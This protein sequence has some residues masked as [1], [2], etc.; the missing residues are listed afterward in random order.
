MEEKESRE[1]LEN[2][3]LY[4]NLFN[5]ILGELMK[6][7]SENQSERILEV[8][9]K[10]SN[11][12]RENDVLLKGLISEE[13]YLNQKNK[14]SMMNQDFQRVTESFDS[15]IRNIFRESLKMSQL[16]YGFLE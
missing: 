9:S 15:C 3:S 1:A 10:V 2:F 16:A 8:I 5:K 11:I 13:N 12:Q 7:S 4:C 6:H 14:Y